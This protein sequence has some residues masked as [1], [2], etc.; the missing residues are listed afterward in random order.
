[1]TSMGNASF[2]TR[3]LLR[4]SP[5][6]G[7]VLV[8]VLLVAGVVVGTAMMVNVFRERALQSAERE[9][10]NTGSL[11]ARHFDQQLENFITIQR[12]IATQVRSEKLTTPEAFRAQM[13]T[14]EFHE[15]L[16]AKVSGHDDVAGVNVFDVDGRL[17]NSSEN[18]ASSAV[19]VSDRSYFKAFKSGSASETILIELV[20]SRF[21]DDWAT[22]IAYKIAAPNSEF[23][24][25]I[26]RAITPASFEK[27]FASL[28]LGE[29]GA[30]SMYHRDGT[31]LARYPHV[32]EMIGSNFSDGPVHRQ[33]L[34]K[35]DHGTIRLTSP[36]DGIDRLAS[37]RALSEFPIS[38]I[39][40]TTASAALVDWRE[41]TRF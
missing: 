13:S 17:I 36:I 33:I 11:L 21:S 29:G 28:T 37:A 38:V 41:Q 18:R 4:G 3:A 1:M 31:L 2:N 35:S 22:V 16:K 32:E 27:F 9:L 14:P 5:I 12:E 15:A 25:V 39:A 23:L 34:S 26:T 7:L 30:I 6:R 10:S 19:N 24:G 8:G 40:T 20:H